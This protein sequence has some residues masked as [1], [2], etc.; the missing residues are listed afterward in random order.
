MLISG[1]QA[2]ELL[3]EIGL[4]PEPARR[5]L[6]AGVAGPAQRTRGALLYD[7]AAVRRLLVEPVDQTRVDERCWD[8]MFVARVGPRKE[9]ADENRSWQGADLTASIDE[10]RDGVR[11]YW[12]IAPLTRLCIARMVEVRGYVPFVATV[13]GLVVVGGD[14]TGLQLARC[15]RGVMLTLEEPSEWFEPFRGRRFLTRPG[16]PWSWWPA[17]LESLL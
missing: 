2:A 1:R 8:G 10:Q 12:R 13:S 11:M 17:R 7:E 6:L 14:M 15:G 16:G 9:A 4:G 5:A 3:A